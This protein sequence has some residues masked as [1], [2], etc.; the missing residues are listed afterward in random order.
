[1]KTQT[2]NKDMHDRSVKKQGKK[3]LP[4]AEKFN[5]RVFIVFSESTE[6]AALPKMSF[7]TTMLSVYYRDTQTHTKSH[8]KAQ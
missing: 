3:V 8:T 5:F 2:K 7:K 1:M 4:R 6:A